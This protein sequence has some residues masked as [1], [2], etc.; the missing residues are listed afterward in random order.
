MIR[1]GN[2]SDTTERRAAWKANTATYRAAHPEKVKASKAA[3]E[4]KYPER[5]KAR[6][7]AWWAAHPE[8]LG[9]YGA[10]RYAKNPEKEKARIKA[11]KMANPQKV[12]VHKTNR[13]V[14]KK[15]NGGKLSPDIIPKL[16]FLQHGKCAICKSWLNGTRYHLDHVVPL[17]RG[18]M[19]TDS[20]V[21]LT[22]QKCNQEKG[23]KDPILFL[24]EKGYSP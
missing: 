19:D 5:E 4:A 21:Q 23:G 24:R 10:A 15:S 14:R 18:G 8:K 11:W 3:Y 16:L 20:N 12:K 22:C 9:F 13:Q 2:D 7:A 17:V 6:K 1:L